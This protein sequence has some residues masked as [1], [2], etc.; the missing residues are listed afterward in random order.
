M[1]ELQSLH[2]TVISA[3]DSVAHSPVPVTARSRQRKSRSTWH[4]RD[5][6]ATLVEYALLVALISIA[7]V[8]SLR[9][10]GTS[11]KDGVSV[12]NSKMFIAP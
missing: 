3:T 11:T 10:L 7:A 4:D 12:S 6:G 5:R 2:C 1:L 8:V 9:F